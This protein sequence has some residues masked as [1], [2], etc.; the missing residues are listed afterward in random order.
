MSLDKV[1]F[2]LPSAFVVAVND[3]QI[4][5]ETRGLNRGR[6]KDEGSCKS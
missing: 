6:E 3:M 5:M 4:V 1:S 2:L